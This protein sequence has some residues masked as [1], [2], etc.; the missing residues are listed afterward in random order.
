MVI[1]P[2]SQ[3]LL[4]HAPMKDRGEPGNEA[5]GQL[6]LLPGSSLHPDER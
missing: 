3:G 4:P 1:Q 2:R 5:E 6:A